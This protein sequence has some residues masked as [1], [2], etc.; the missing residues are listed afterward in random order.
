M[1]YFKLS[2]TALALGALSLTAFCAVSTPVL[3]RDQIR[4]TG[5]STVFPFATT[6]AEKLGSTRKFKTPIVESTGTGGGIKQFCAGIGL[7]FPDIV[8]ASRAIK[9]SE[10]EDCRKNGVMGVA[11]LKIGYDGIVIANAKSAAPAAFTRRELYQALAQTV[12]VDGNF[13]ANPYQKW[14]DIDAKLPNGAIEVMGP[15]P[16]SGTRDALVE[17]VMVAGCGTFPEIVKQNDDKEVHD[18]LCKQVRGPRAYID[19]GENDNLIVK[20]LAVTPG[21][22]GIF[23]YSFLEQNAD[24]VQAATVD[25]VTPT[26]E[27]IASGKYPVSRPLFLYVK[28]SHVGVVAGLKEYMAEFLSERA[29]GTEG[30]LSQKGLIPMS[31]AEHKTMK[32]NAEKLPIM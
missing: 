6:V 5:S 16:T 3:A 11:E 17:L 18:K 31:A 23:G 10:I 29:A 8:M 28:K 2:A 26:F 13:V 30:Y 22:F 12:P 20:K 32:D 19:S 1:N 15:P 25:G 7:D 27:N 9:K 24:S 14:S 4:I 21:A